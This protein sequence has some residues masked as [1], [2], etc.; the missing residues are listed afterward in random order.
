MFHHAHCY[1]VGIK[2]LAESITQM[3]GGAFT[4]RANDL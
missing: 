2:T 3:H 1:Q 4:N